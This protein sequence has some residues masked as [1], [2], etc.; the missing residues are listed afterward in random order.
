[1]K[2]MFISVALV[3]LLVATSCAGSGSKSESDIA[4]KTQE[5]PKRQGWDDYVYGPLYG[6]VESVTYTKYDIADKFGEIVNGKCLEKAVYKFNL[7][8]DVVEEARYNGDGSL[9]SKT[10]YKYDERGNQ[11]EEATYNGDGSLSVKNLYK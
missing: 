3:A 9:C 6:D 1:M 4:Y 5:A 10:L 7:K 2:R 11:I 8:G